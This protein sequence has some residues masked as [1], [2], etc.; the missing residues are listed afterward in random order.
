MSNK[1]ADNLSRDLFISYDE[2]NP[3][4]ST[5]SRIYG[6]TILDQVFDPLTPTKKTLREILEE[7]RV[8]IRTGGRPPIVFPV[9]S[10]NGYTGDVVVRPIDLGLDKVDN[11]RDIDKPLS[12][13]QLDSVMTILQN[14]RFSINLTRFDE[15]L[16]NRDNPHNVRIEH[17]DVDNELTNLIDRNVGAS[18]FDHN[19]SSSVSTHRDIRRMI[20]A[21]SDRITEYKAEIDDKFREVDEHALALDI[22]SQQHRELLD[23]KESLFNKV[24]VF[25]DD[26]NNNNAL[27]P[28]TKAIMNLINSKLDNLD[29]TNYPVITTIRVV[30]DVTM[31]PIASESL[32]RSVYFIR[33][34][35]EARMAV[36]VCEKDQDSYYWEIVDSGA[37]SKLD[38]RF[39]V[40]NTYGVSLNLH[41]LSDALIHGG[42]DPTLPPFLAVEKLEILSGTMDGFI[43]YYVNDDMTT[44]KEVRVAGL[45]SM[46]F[47]EWLIDRNIPNNLITEKQK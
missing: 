33:N 12:N 14:Y 1:L 19:R 34:T 10:V 35:D 8:E 39:F 29:I 4:T 25:D 31:L 18:I 37:V 24:S 2:Q 11:T 15:H 22:N 42:F 38:S 41:A 6:S 36:A 40:N 3:Q 9:T 16:L 30:S 13:P 21:E 7:I 47:Q 27:Y 45:K 32:Y 43:R 46:A 28:S 23:Q 5:I 17:L 26:I 44:M 20:W